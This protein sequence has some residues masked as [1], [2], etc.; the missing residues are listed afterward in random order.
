MFINY[1]FGINMKKNNKGFSL[2]EL[3]IVLIIMGLLIAGVTGG[4]SLIKSAKLRSVITEFT[5]YRTAYK[6]Y[7]AQFGQVPSDDDVN[8]ICNYEAFNVLFNEG[9]IDREPIDNAIASKFG[10]NVKWHLVDS[11]N[12]VGEGEHFTIPDFDNTNILT[13]ANDI[14]LS[15]PILTANEIK[16]IDEKVDDGKSKSGLVRGI[17]AEANG[18]HQEQEYDYNT[19]YTTEKG[20]HW[21]LVSKMDF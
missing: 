7:Y 14:S 15:N 20:K 16:S 17:F 21:S 4:A 9:I 18:D 8:K 12:I 13:L 11:N 10:G 5:N 1:F 19:E 6:T 3:S 2:I